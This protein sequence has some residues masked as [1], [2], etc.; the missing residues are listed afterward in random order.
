MSG[1]RGILSL[2]L[3]MRRRVA[4]SGACRCIRRFPSAGSGIGL[5]GYGFRPISS[6]SGLWRRWCLC[7]VHGNGYLPAAGYRPCLGVSSGLAG[8]AGVGFRL[9]SA[10][11]ILCLGVGFVLCGLWCGW[12]PEL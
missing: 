2:T 8:S 4:A 9:L 10:G 12:N 1:I 5:P 3:C 6:A 11:W 7:F